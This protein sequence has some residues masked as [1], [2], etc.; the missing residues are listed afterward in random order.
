MKTKGQ[1]IISDFKHVTNCMPVSG[2]ECKWWNSDADVKLFNNRLIG[3]R[4]WMW[5]LLDVALRKKMRMSLLI[6]IAVKRVFF[7]SE[8]YVR[9]ASNMSV[10]LN[11]FV[12]KCPHHNTPQEIVNKRISDYWFWV[13]LPD[14][15]MCLRP[16]GQDIWNIR[17]WTW[18]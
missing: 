16:T 17:G 14:C 18:I 9:W 11:S 1:V 8:G 4:C 13:N 7:G 10:I 3:L 5:N 6:R 15:P 12:L 2:S